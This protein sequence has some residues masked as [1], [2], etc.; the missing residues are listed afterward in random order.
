MPSRLLAIP[1]ALTAWLGLAIQFG[2]SMETYHSISATLWVML[3]YFTIIANL[4]VALLFTAI[5][6]GRSR[7]ATPFR[8]GGVTIAILL[9]GIV[10]NLL[11]NGM[12]QLSGGAKLADVINHSIT[13]TLVTAYWLIA[14][15]KGR[16]AWRAP[17]QWTALPTAY[18]AYALTRAG[19]DGKYPYPFMDVTH[20]GW[21]RTIGNAAAMA[22]CFVV[23]GFVMVWWDRRSAGGVRKD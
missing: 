21:P 18:F 2:A 13:P 5:A 23:V 6:L 15:D 10:Y 20:L 14:R 3:L 11:L 9:V 17:L 8:L 16:L 7:A 22:L 12:I 19:I 4:L 1:I